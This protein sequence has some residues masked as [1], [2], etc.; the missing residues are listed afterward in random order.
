MSNRTRIGTRRAWVWQGGS[1]VATAALIFSGWSLTC[2]AVS[3]GDAVMEWNQIALDATVT[4]GQGPLPQSRSMTIVQVSVHDSVNTIT[5]KYKTYL[6]NGPAPAGASQDAAAIAAA[7]RALVSL[8][9]TQAV[10]LDAARVASLAA[11]S[12]TEANP[13]I[14]VGENAA[15]AIL[16][17]RAND[18]ASQAQFAYTAPG[19]GTPGVWVTIGT[20]QP[21]LPGWGRVTHWVMHNS[22]QFDP[23]GPPPLG[24]DRYARDYREVQEIGSLTSLTRTPVQTEIARFWLGTP[25]AI[26]NRVARQIIEAQGLDRSDTARVF[27]LMYL[28]ASDAG[29]VCWDA[30]YTFNFWR[31]MAAIRNGHLDGN[32]ATVGDPAWQPLF[33]T[34]PHPEYLSGHSTNSSAM[35]TMLG[36]LFGDNP[37]VPIVALSPTNPGFP[38]DWD[39]FSEGV[40]EVINA[41]IYSGI[42][43]RTADEVGARVGRQV[44]RFVLTHALR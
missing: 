3:V 14:A 33:P 27:A 1:V 5:G 32:D 12:L 8:F 19:G 18:G 4:A 41:R 34:P 2:S 42:H 23:G 35:A 11:R 24:S 21:L 13:G 29:I 16:S 30:K 26:W 31:P 39:T 36:F 15:A 28:A 20:A 44:A 22:A 25:S 6:P 43:Y 40:E 10:A 9:P 7:H 17:V 37:G 38:R